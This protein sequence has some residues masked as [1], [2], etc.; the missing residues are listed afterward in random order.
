MTPRKNPDVLQNPYARPSHVRDQVMSWMRTQS[1]PVS[2]DECVIG[3]GLSGIAVR[4]HLRNLAGLG[5]IVRVK[6]D[7]GNEASW[8]TADLA[9][10]VE[11]EEWPCPGRRAIGSGDVRRILRPAAEAP[12]VPVVGTPWIFC[13]AYRHAVGVQA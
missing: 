1:A 2:T 11:F 4:H 3:T 13:Q 10:E 5:E 6:S 8:V 12:R 9:D 7:F